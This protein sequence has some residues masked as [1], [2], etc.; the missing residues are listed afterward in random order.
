M[1]IAH[2]RVAGFLMLVVLASLFATTAT[3]QNKRRLAYAD[4][5]STDADF[6]LQGEYLGAFVEEDLGRQIGLQIVAK[7]D[8]KF[9]AVEYTGGLPGTRW[10][11]RD[12]YK[13]TGQVR[14]GVIHFKSPRHAFRVSSGSAE[15]LTTDGQLL[16][17]LEKVHRISP[18]VG[19]RPPKG[20]IVLFNGKDT[21]HFSRAKMTKD[22]L[23]QEGTETVQPFQNFTLHLEFRL[24]Y[25]PF[26]GGQ[27]R[28]NSGIYIQSRYEVQILDS[29]GLDGVKNECGAM[30]RQRKPDLNMCLPPL[31]WQTYDITFRSPTFDAAG[32]KTAN[33]RITVR[34]NGVLVQD[35][36]ELTNKTGAGRP[37]GA[38]PLRTK[39]QN[40]G[41]PIRFRNIWLVKQP[42]AKQ[43]AAKT[44]VRRRTLARRTG[45]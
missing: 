28:A 4:P 34:H 23:L 39:I 27:G 21:R 10:N 31:Q 2:R 14:D 26:A 9:A 33:A 5:K 36:V 37:E 1:T 32:K 45:N 29:F 44:D 19:K 7:G 22:G 24:P 40:H 42:A 43:I 38:K 41:N 15:I 17:Q 13:M 20:A 30:Y 35:N 8:G 6:P 12:R 18:T 16:G 25:M 3:A 11:L